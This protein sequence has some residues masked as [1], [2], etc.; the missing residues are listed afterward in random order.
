MVILGLTGSIGM[1]K[2]TAA[3][4]LRRL[5]IPVHDADA[6]VHRLL[7]KGGGAVAPIAAAFPGVVRDGAVDRQALG[8]QVFDNPD[9][10]RWLESIVHPRV[11]ASLRR[12]LADAARRR[13]KVV[14]LDVPLLF[15]TGGDRRTDRTVV[16]TAP[17]FVQRARVLARSGMT[18]AKLAAILA[19]QMPDVEKRRR[20]DFVVPTGLGRRFTLKAL[21]RVVRLAKGLDGRHWPPRRHFPGSRLGRHAGNR[22]GH[23]NHGR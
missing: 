1:G 8:A 23:R 22:F 14:V 9:K 7:A 12:F 18:E 15:E 19:R 4:M 16:V 11:Q 10:L 20:A 3:R 17:R 13:M 6:V 21:V 5:G 2:S